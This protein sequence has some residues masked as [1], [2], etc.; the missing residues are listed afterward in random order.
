M[1][2]L[3]A[4]VFSVLIP[5]SWMRIQWAR[6]AAPNDRL[7][8]ACLTCRGS[9]CLFATLFEPTRRSRGHIEPPLE[10]RTVRQTRCRNTLV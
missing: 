9:S 1:R 7:D 6:L 4:S 10:F 2:F 3:V 5:F 8:R